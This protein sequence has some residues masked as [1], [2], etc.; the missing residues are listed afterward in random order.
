MRAGKLRHR[1]TIQQVTETRSATG[2]V[3]EAW[4]DVADVWAA[5]EPLRGR[6][7]F[8]SKEFQ[9]QVDTRIRI[10]YYPG[11]IPKM[12]VLWGTRIYLVDSVI[13]PEERDKELQLMCREIVD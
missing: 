9:A 4:G 7:F 1:V 6:E 10:R 11:V 2:A 5:V 3:V 8:A 12:R 13:N